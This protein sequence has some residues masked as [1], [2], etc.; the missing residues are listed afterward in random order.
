[1]AATPGSTRTR[2][3]AWE[4][5]AADLLEKNGLEILERNVEI[6]HAEL[7]MVARLRASP[8]D[9]VDTIVF[10]EVRGRSRDCH[11]DP[12]ET[13]DL[14]KRRQIARAGRAW[15]VAHGLWERV[16]VRFDVIGIVEAHGADAT[17]RWIPNA[18]DST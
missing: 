6:A 16:A 18:F 13:V 11:G 5:R 9:E 4:D 12:L 3:R 17:V 7:D 10:V 2:G 14:R 1:M 8:T 15:L